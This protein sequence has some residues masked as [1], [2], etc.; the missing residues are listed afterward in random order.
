MI[1]G[2]LRAALGDPTAWEGSIRRFEAADRKHP[3]KPGG[4][5][6]VGGSSFTQW[7][8]LASDMAPLPVI[9]R[10]F[11]GA[12]LEDVVNY[13]S[14]VVIPCQPRAIVV[15][16][17]ANDIASLRPRTPAQVE[18]SFVELAR[19]VRHALPE[20]LLFYVA[21]TPTPKGWSY[22][23][24]M[25]E[26]NQRIRDVVRT[27]SRLRCIDLNDLLLGPD[28]KPIAGLYL[29]NGHPNPS[30]YQLWTSRIRPALLACHTSSAC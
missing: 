1:I 14:R 24:P 29:R 25:S 23:G 20:A 27:D 22:W 18:A 13:A 19:I 26:A 9:N 15:F 11:G 17:G 30:C 6:F 7:S 8:S 3:P 16:A 10:G 12:T 21:M 4:I 5:V 2:T 28:G